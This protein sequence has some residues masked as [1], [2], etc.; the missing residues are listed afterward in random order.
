MKIL[1]VGPKGPPVGGTTVL[2]EQLCDYIEDNTETELGVIN[3]AA[4]DIGR[5][6]VNIA[7][8]LIRIF[9]QVRKYDI[10][11][12]HA[13]STSMIPIVTGVLRLSSFLFGKKFGFRGF[14]GRFPVY[15][16]QQSEW[17]RRILKHTVLAADQLFFET[18]ESVAFA[19]T[20]T[21]A[22]VHWFPNSRALSKLPEPK[23]GR[24]NKFVFISHVKPSKGVRVLLEA[25]K[26]L[27]GI[28][29]DVYGPLQ[30]G[31]T[32]D[33]FE[34]SLV[35]Y[36][37]VLTSDQVQETLTLYDVLLLP[38]F[39]AGEGYPGIVLEAYAEGMPVITTNWRCIPEIADDTSAILIEPENAQEL[40]DAILRISADEALADTLRTGASEKAKLFSNDKWGDFFLETATTLVK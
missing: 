4:S 40:R 9:F 11:I 21:D 1:L 29:I 38:T 16:E 13:S 17:K 8:F 19:Q 2:F 30:D 35:N 33:E 15:W 12:L 20:L 6:P 34:D 25:A 32:E 22:S 36:R 27:N 10:A 7:G 24:V 26:D 5:S 28:E 14:G 18:K 23:T 39:Y 31:I 3:S 37:G